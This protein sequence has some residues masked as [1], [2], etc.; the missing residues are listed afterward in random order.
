[1]AVDH[2]KM[3]TAPLHCEPQQGRWGRCA[4]ALGSLTH[5]LTCARQSRRPHYLPAATHPPLLLL[6]LLR[7]LADAAAETQTPTHSMPPQLSAAAKAVHA[8]PHRSQTPRGHVS[9]AEHR[10][11]AVGDR[12]ASD[13]AA[14]WHRWHR[15]T[16]THTAVARATERRGGCPADD[17][18]HAA[19]ATLQVPSAAPHSRSRGSAARAL[20]TTPPMAAAWTSA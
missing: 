5:S 19:S 13:E 6:P 1:M 9:E 2:G 4:G 10:L 17:R 16:H 8:P 18:P 3:G 11:D 20:P 14:P 7:T 12:L 15:L